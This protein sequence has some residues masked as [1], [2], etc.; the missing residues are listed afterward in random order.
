MPLLFLCNEKY[1]I[2]CGKDIKI[3]QKVLSNYFIF[4]KN[5]LKFG[6]NFG[7]IVLGIVCLFGGGII[8]WRRCAIFIQK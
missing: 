6:P 1:V 8:C 7:I 3:C 4:A 2:F 5:T